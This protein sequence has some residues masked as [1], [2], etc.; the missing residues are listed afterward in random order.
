[1][2]LPAP[3]PA[4]VRVNVIGPF[5]VTA[6]DG[7]DLT[8][9]GA[10]P[11]ALI[12]MLALSP[13]MRRP[14]RWLEDKL[15]STSPEKQAGASLRQALVK[16]RGAFGDWS[17]ALEAER[18]AIGLDPTRVQVILRQ[19]D[20]EMPR[21]LLEGLDARDPEFDEWLR[22]ERTRHENRHG[23]AALHRPA[24]LTLMCRTQVRTEAMPSLVGEVLA[25]RIGD[26]IS[27]QVRAW[28]HAGTTDGVGAEIVGDLDISCDMIETAE[29][30]RVYVRILH[31][32]TR[33]ILYSR[34]IEVDDVQEIL[35]ASARV[36]AIVFEAADWALTA[37]PATL[38][39]ARPEAQATDLQRRALT[40]MFSFQPGALREADALLAQAHEIEGN[41]IYTAWRSLA[42]TIQLIELLEPDREALIDEIQELN[43]SALSEAP[44]NA[45]VLALLSQVRI[46]ALGD[47]AG[48]VDLAERSVERNAS[49]G[50]GW[51]SLSVSRML[52]GE[53]SQ[54]MAL[55]LRARE[56]ARYSPFRH[57]WDLYHCITCVA[58]DHSELAIEAAEAAVRQAPFFRP[59]Y[60]HLVA[61][62]AQQGRFDRA[63][64][65]AE[66]LERIEPGFTL[67]RLVNDD[68]Y[69]VRTLRTKGLLDPVRAML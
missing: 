65:I 35:G 54:A 47:A 61:L 58:N 60:R 7:T 69:P 57:W 62:Y 38:D 52:A 6:A 24:G 41:G 44:N 56:I 14:R 48:G 20:Y 59:A 33:R 18:T 4:S 66:R 23:N 49:S 12:A 10:K 55:S 39:R 9:L 37:L 27:E 13:G 42:R 67:D 46:M 15:W 63:I 5:S 64:K 17:D 31:P 34:L 45:L 32:A 53:P 3:D 21:E 26:A 8:P 43:Y 29:G 50:F 28:R 16:I 40:R 1:M 2:S 30:G 19:N 68:T 51:L 25:E 11:Q 36:S 22:D